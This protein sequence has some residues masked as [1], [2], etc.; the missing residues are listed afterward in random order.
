MKHTIRIG[1]RGSKLAL[2]QAYRVKDELVQK[3]P[4]KQFEIVVI[5]TKGDK[6]LDVPLSKI[7]DKGLFTKELEVAMFNDE[8]DMAVHSLKDLPTI[9]PEGTK[10]GAVLERGTVNDALV[11]KDH[12]KL[13]EL[14]SEHTIATSSLRRKAQLLKL[15]PDFNIVEI[16]GNVNTRIR[17]MNEGYCD[18]MIMAGAGLQRLEMDEAITEILDPKTMIPACGQG[19]IAI[20]IKDNDL[21]IEAIIAQINHKETM[22]T[23]SAERVFLN[24][25][26]GGCQIPV[27]S[28]CKID[29]D[30]VKITGFIAS[31]DGSKFLKETATGPVENANEISK[32][33]ANKLFNAGGKE[34]L[35]AI[36]DENLPSA[37][38]ELP[39]KDKVII[40]TRPADI[41]ND[42]PEL[43]TKAG[44]SVVSLPMIQIEQRQLMAAEEKCLQELDQFQWVIF[45]SKNGVISFFKQLIEIKGNT[46]LPN[47]LKIG[48]IG[49]N[50]AA[51]L[52][53]YGYAPYFT[54]NENTSD[55]LLKELKEKH[56][57]QN[58]NILLALGNLAGDKL[59]TEL[60]KANSVTRINT[61]QTVKPPGTDLNIL[62]SI[63]NEHYDL[64]VFTSPSTFN[65]FCHFYC[66]ENIS[67]VKMASIGETTS[68]AIRQGGAE[69]LITAK[70]SN[71]EGLY[72]AIID[73]YQTK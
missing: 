7:G 57:L 1:T 13:S 68:E 39:L 8:I 62:K 24:T 67:E 14:T 11:S 19:A 31:I 29:G 12:L 5:K 47:D 56:S 18:A 66:T 40:S 28:T 27:G 6:I 35:D 3:F 53:Y 4:E 51:E 59:E 69:P 44:A 42:L 25:L 41:H 36:R 9:F 30:Q 61:Y 16:R 55:G 37:Q 17:K 10:L 58:Q 52:D 50:T 54:A 48:V 63:S 33:L 49:K 26:E 65:N 32:E 21:E 70:D 38:T 45:T 43:L 64:I 23:S 22:I 15:N 34:I 72:K 2:Y 20:E 73:Y 46:T 71:A 60:S